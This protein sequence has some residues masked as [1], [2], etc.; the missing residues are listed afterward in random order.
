M[1]REA[2]DLSPVP[3]LPRGELE[4][5]RGRGVAGD[6]TRRDLAAQVDHPPLVV[7]EEDLDREAH[8]EGV[9]ASASRD[10]QA[11]IGAIGVQ[12]GEAQGPAGEGGGDRNGT[13]E[14]LRAPEAAKP[15]RSRHALLSPG[16]RARLPL[17]SI[18][19]L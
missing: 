5:G 4:D 9:D 13:P 19:A 14:D 11:L 8:P 3:G 15:D 7:E 12:V 1:R 10:Q 16:G 2:I 18:R 6:P 17:R